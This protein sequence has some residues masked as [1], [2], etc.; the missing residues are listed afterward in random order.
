MANLWVPL[1]IALL[2]NGMTLVV[3][4]IST[5]NARLNEAARQ[6]SE[7]RRL[8]AGRHDL[9][10]QLAIDQHEKLAHLRQDPYVRC[11]QEFRKTSVVVHD[12]GYANEELP[13]DWQLAA[14]E[15]VLQL[16]VFAD[17]N[18]REAAH[19]AY[20][21]LYSWGAAGPFNHESE[22]ERLFNRARDSFLIAIRHDLRIEVD[23]NRLSEADVVR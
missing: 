7:D 1:A 2:S 10:V 13:A 4:L 20:S 8:E 5:R 9:R 15:A 19:D 3:L 14:Y 17:W 12:A 22:Q 21:A 23:E 18:T 6:S 11:F 16:E